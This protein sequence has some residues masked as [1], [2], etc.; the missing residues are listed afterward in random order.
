VWSAHEHEWVNAMSRDGTVPGLEERRQYLAAHEEIIVAI[1]D[2][3]P[4]RAAAVAAA[5]LRNSERPL[6]AERDVA[7]NASLLQSP[8]AAPVANRSRASV[9]TDAAGTTRES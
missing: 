8:F 2:G 1:A 6:I 7:V 9:R 3:D 5:H 4:G